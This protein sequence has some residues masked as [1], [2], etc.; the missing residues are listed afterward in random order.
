MCR[1]YNH[2][3]FKQIY[4]AHYVV[5]MCVSCIRKFSLLFLFHLF[6]IIIIVL[7]RLYVTAIQYN[8]WDRFREEGPSA[9]FPVRVI[10]VTLALKCMA[11]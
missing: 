1:L 5:Q 10:N 8:N 6:C 4:N 11:N 3:Y 7:C 2:Y 9:Y